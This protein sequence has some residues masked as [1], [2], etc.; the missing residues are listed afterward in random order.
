MNFGSAWNNLLKHW[1]SSNFFLMEGY[2][3]VSYERNCTLLL[4]QSAVKQLLWEG[5]TDEFW[6]YLEYLL[7]HWISSEFLLMEG[8]VQG[9]L[10]KE[11]HIAPLVERFK[12]AT[13]GRSC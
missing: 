8:Y 3:Q 11:L 5:L 13:L 4:S 6:Q 12:A 10:R 9:V 7:K 1:I 2:V